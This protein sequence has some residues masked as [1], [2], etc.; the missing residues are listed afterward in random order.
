MIKVKYVPVLK[1]IVLLFSALILLCAVPCAFAAT[2]GDTP[3]WATEYINDLVNSGSISGADEDGDGK[4]DDL[5]PLEEMRRAEFVT[6]LAKAL[7]MEPEI[8]GEPPFKDVDKKH[9][10]L[11]YLVAVTG[12]N[13]V[14]AEML[15]DGLFKPSQPVTREEI[16]AILVNVMRK[17]DEALN[18]TLADLKKLA[19]KDT[20][21]EAWS[22]P[23]IIVAIKNGIVK[24]YDDKTFKPQKTVIRAEA[25]VMIVRTLRQ[26][27]Q[28]VLLEL[29]LIEKE[30][31]YTGVIIDC[32]G[33]D[34]KGSMAPSLLDEDGNIV[35]GD[36]Q[37]SEY[38]ET[39]GVMGYYKSEEDAKERAGKNPIIVVAIEV[40][41]QGDFKINPVISNEDAKKILEENKDAKF[42][43]K[44]RVAVLK[45]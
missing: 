9:W 13:L 31:L 18:L 41:G 20:P 19:L 30:G 15:A 38:L 25:F 11:P 42:L 7:K 35:Y 3:D 37:L 21:L 28:D 32:R 44:F 34:I 16:A 26:I 40:R 14:P 5:K 12:K 4:P 33:I 45:D 29:G 43:E 10:A 36:V 24:G 17:Q 22:T 8:P 27:P 23:F 2:S 1:Q 6:V 39:I